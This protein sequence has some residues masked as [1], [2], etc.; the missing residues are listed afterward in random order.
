MLVA[1]LRAHL[2]QGIFRPKKKVDLF[3]EIGRVK[4][5]LS[6]T[7]PHESNVYEN[8]YFLFQKKTHTQTKKLPLANLFVRI[9]VFSLQTITGRALCFSTK[10]SAVRVVFKCK[11]YSKSLIELIKKNFAAAQGKIFFVTRISGNQSTIF[12]ALGP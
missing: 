2:Q 9:Y 7:R 12:L 4:F 10:K 3:R 5:L 1:F 8:I 11:L 6:P